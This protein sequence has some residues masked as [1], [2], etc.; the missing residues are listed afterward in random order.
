MGRMS[1]EQDGMEGVAFKQMEVTEGGERYQEGKVRIVRG[2]RERGGP[3][4]DSNYLLGKNG[5]E[6]LGGLRTDLS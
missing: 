6:W 1:V 3:V 5:L 4:E 2:R